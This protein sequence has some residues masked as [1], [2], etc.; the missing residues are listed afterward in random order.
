VSQ[1]KDDKLYLVHIVECISSIEDYTDD[2]PESIKEHTMVRD[3]VLRNLQTLAE[4]TQRLS[5]GFKKEYSEIDWGGIAG[6]RNQLVHG[7]LGIDEQTIVD[8]IENDLP[9]LK[10]TVLEALVKL[11]NKL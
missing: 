10:Q 3:A 1:P 6:F 2:R 5:E 9:P 11:K 4:S 7:Y 8:V